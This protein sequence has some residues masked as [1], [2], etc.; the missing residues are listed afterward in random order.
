VDVAVN[1]QELK[2]LKSKLKAVC[3]IAF[4][5]YESSKRMC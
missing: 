3:M 2:N 4:P 5:S 1:L